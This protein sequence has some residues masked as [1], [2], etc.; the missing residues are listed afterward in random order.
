[1]AREPKDATRSNT[2]RIWGAILIVVFVGMN[3]GPH[4]SIRNV[5][6][7]ESPEAR[8][9]SMIQVV[10]DLLVL[11]AGLALLMIDFLRRRRGRA[12]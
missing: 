4:S 5:L 11:L 2:L 10:I 12:E 3:L 6:H 9:Q 8:G 7:A 1:M